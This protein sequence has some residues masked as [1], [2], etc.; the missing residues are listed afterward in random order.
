MSA[1]ALDMIYELSIF[2]SKL[3]NAGR[4]ERKKIVILSEKLRKTVHLYYIY[5][6]VEAS[7]DDRNFVKKTVHVTNDTSK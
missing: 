3:A 2:S 1:I 4:Y 6:L 7:S 5:T